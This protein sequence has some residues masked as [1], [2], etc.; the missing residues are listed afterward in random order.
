VRQYFVVY[1]FLT[2]LRS[3]NE[4]FHRRSTFLHLWRV[5]ILFLNY[6]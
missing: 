6:C 4:S 5:C 2:I 3:S 1:A